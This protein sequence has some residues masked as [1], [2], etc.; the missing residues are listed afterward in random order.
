MNVQDMIKQVPVRAIPSCDGGQPRP[1]A[2]P[3]NYI[4]FAAT[5]AYKLILADIRT[6]TVGR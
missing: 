5:V 2:R 1:L 6:L 4:K 3:Y